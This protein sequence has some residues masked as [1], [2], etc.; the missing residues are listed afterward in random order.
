MDNVYEKGKDVVET[1]DDTGVK[2]L[3]NK[4]NVT[5]EQGQILENAAENSEYVPE[6][7]TLIEV[8]IDMTKPGK[9][10]ARG[11]NPNRRVK[12]APKKYQTDSGSIFD[13]ETTPTETIPLNSLTEQAE[14]KKTDC[15]PPQ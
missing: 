14:D 13:S 7:D 10:K 11:K 8:K 6:T 15:L 9:K 3:D 2:S 4:G 1:I 5:N 12:P